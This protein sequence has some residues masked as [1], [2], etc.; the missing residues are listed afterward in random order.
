MK[1]LKIAFPTTDS[2]LLDSHFYGCKNFKVFNIENDKVTSTYLI[3]PPPY[4][5]GDM[6]K[7]LVKEKIDVIISGPM[8]EAT[9]NFLKDHKID[10]I[11]GMKGIMTDL[12]RLYLI[13]E[14]KSDGTLY[15]HQNYK[16]H[17]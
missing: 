10:V 5:H 12:I 1:N 13:G 7:F 8:G 2:I 6:P 14:L 11:Y 4:V 9:F 17:L 3:T 16:N 15:N